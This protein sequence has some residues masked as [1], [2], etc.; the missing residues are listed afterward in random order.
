MEVASQISGATCVVTGIEVND[1]GLSEV[2]GTSLSEAGLEGVLGC[3]SDDTS[4][5]GEE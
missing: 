4:E 5:E 1:L 3:S 2:L